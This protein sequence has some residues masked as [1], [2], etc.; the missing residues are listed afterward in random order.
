MLGEDVDRLETRYP[1]FLQAQLDDETDWIKARLRKRYVTEGFDAS[2]PGIALKWLNAIVTLTAYDKRG[3]D[4]LSPEGLRTVKASED[5]KAEIKEAAD[6]EGGLFD[7]PLRS[8]VQASGIS[9]G[10][11]LGY[12]EQSPYTAF[13]RQ[14]EAIARNG[15]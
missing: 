13:D 9:Q 11:P 1:G 15:E 3:L 12:A 5:A 4:T 6:A 10:S 2:P 14:R 8:D 7:L